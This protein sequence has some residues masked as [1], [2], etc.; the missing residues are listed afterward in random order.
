MAAKKRRPTNRL[1]REL[2]ETAHD[3]WLAGLGAW[4]KA[5]AEGTKLFQGFVEQGR[6]LESKGVPALDRLREQ[7]ST[8]FA[9]V[10]ASLN[11]VAEEGAEAFRGGIARA[12]KG[13][14]RAARVLGEELEGLSDRWEA[15]GARAKRATRRTAGRAKAGARKSAART[16]RTARR[17]A[18]KRR[19]AR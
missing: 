2:R 5:K 15:K 14:A 1:G 16:S 18:P 10:K 12:K 17:A 4:S 9:N 3:V 19:R 7:A 6:K 8:L 11:E 13:S